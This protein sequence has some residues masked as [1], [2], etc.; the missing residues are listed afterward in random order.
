METRALNPEAEGAGKELKRLK[1]KF[2]RVLVDAP[3]TGTGTWRRN[4]DMRWR[5]Q[6]PD[7]DE[8]TSLQ[9][10]LLDKAAPLVKP[11]GRLIYVTCSLLPAENEA[12]AQSFLTRRP[13]FAALDLAEIWPAIIAATGGGGW[14]GGGPYLRLTPYR[15]DTDGFFVAAFERAG[16][17]D[18][19]GEAPTEESAAP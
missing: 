7:I 6:G 5:R 15:H 2:D 8:L 4:P 18:Q 9:A 13:D 1:G 10:R 14:P 17:N 11:G 3:C 12:Q 16:V 19:A